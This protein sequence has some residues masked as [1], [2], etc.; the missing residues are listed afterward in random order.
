M[1]EKRGGGVKLR[2]AKDGEKYGDLLIERGYYG[3]S[4]RLMGSNMIAARVDVHKR[5]RPESGP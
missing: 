3:Q 4:E 1:H 2:K 5:Y